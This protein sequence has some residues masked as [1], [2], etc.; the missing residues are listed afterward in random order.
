MAVIVAL[1]TLSVLVVAHEL[2]HFLSA[3]MAGMR[4]EEFGFGLPPRIWGRK[5]GET[6]YSLNALPFGGF[7]KIQGE[8]GPP[9]PEASAAEAVP[10]RSFYEKPVGVRFL[11]LAAG[12]AMNFILGIVLFTI[13]YTVGLPVVV[14]ERNRS[15]LGDLHVEIV[16]VVKDSPSGKAG[17]AVGDRL[18]ELAFGSKVLK[19]DSV[20]AIQNFVARYAGKEITVKV[21]RNGGHESVVMTP[22]LNPPAGQGP[23]G[24]ALAEVG[25][26]RYPWYR[27]PVEAFRTAADVAWKVVAGLGRL[28]KDLVATRKVSEGVAGPIGI[29]GVAGEA[30]KMGWVRLALFAALLTINLAVLNF[31]PLPALDGGR[32]LFIAVEKLRGRP[33][34]RRLE[35]ATHAAGMAI[36]LILIILISIQDI[37]RLF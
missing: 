25:V 15:E 8:S 27:A 29:V 11:V 4:V 30:A 28:V 22:R 7:V 37:R 14:T 36:L 13:L 35:T 9:S 16:A 33:L 17:L 2:G 21:A 6:L 34:P 10:G 18:E 31:L 23:L 5:R 12:V 20:S 32:A 24:L 26:A 19:P 1:I 3:R